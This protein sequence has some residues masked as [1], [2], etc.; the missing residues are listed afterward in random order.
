MR[1]YSKL[2]ALWL[3]ACTIA[4]PPDKAVTNADGIRSIPVRLFLS[5]WEKIVLIE[6]SQLRTHTLNSVCSIRDQLKYPA[7]GETAISRF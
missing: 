2:S 3:A 4:G 5:D 7:D 6:S 1:L